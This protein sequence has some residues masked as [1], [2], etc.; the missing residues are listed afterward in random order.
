M[1]SIRHR[2]A[3]MSLDLTTA[4]QILG[5]V[6]VLRFAYDVVSGIYNR[7]LRA[8]KDLKKY[9]KW[10]LVTGAT[11]GIGKAYA[12]ELAKRGLNIVLVSRTE[13]KL[14]DVE[15]ELREKYTNTEVMYVAA[16]MGNITPEVREKLEKVVNTVDLG[17]LVNNVGVSYNYPMY[18]HELSDA[19]VK[20]LVDL[21]VHATNTMTR[22]ALPKM[23][24]NKRGAIVNIS[25]AAGDFTNP[26][27]S[28]YNGAKSGITHQTASLA[29]EYASK[30]V[31]FQAQTPLFVS[32]KLAKQRASLTVPTP[33]AFAKQ[34]VNQIGYES[35]TSPFW[36]HAAMSYIVKS[37]PPVVANKQIL[38]MHLV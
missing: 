1:R 31:H 6:V 14:K 25:S 7:F 36:A 16:D 26:L 30:G 34:A 2:P 32:T 35:V 12:F 18:Y 28:G 19:A 11:D 37:L 13:S 23:V 33:E 8:P 24:E 17:V 29:A 15:K 9:G 4:V 21:N 5:W 38:G 27:L 20:S 3:K 10:A 22:I